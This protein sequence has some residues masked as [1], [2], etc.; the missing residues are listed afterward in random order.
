MIKIATAQYDVG[1]LADWDSYQAKLSRWVEQAVTEQATLLLFPEYASMELA[2]LFSKD[3]YSSLSGQLEAMQTLLPRY[4][5]LHEQL[6]K[7]HQIVIVAGS[8]PVAVAE[9]DYRN[10]SYVFLPNGR[11]DFQEKLM[12]TRFENEQWLISA[13]NKIKV[14]DS[15][16]GRFGITICYDSEF[17]RYARHMVEQGAALIVVPSCTDTTAGYHRVRIG[18]QARALENQCYVVQSSLV[19][20]ADWSQAVDVNCGASAVYTPVDKGF[21]DDGVLALGEFNKPSWLYAEID[22]EKMARVRENGQVF[23]YKDWPAQFNAKQYI[24]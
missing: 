19:G 22:L 16:F 12:M 23:N 17:P 24:E 9:K 20:N 8:F 2:S 1:F 3:I 4:L 11:V 13:G 7:Q 14:F 18:C 21:P 15:P 6:A 10:R 5:V